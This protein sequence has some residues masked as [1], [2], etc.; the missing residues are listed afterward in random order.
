[1][2]LNFWFFQNQPF[3]FSKILSKTHNFHQHYYWIWLKP[4]TNSLQVL[5]H[6]REPLGLSSIK[7]EI[8][9]PFG[10]ILAQKLKKIKKK[11]LPKFFFPFFSFWN[12]NRPKWV[13]KFKFFRRQPK[14]LP[15]MRKNLSKNCYWLQPYS[16]IIV[17]KINNILQVKIW[18]VLFYL[19]TYNTILEFLCKWLFRE[20]GL[21]W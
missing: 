19:D 15:F 21:Y 14:R 4:V 5:S 3:I 10:S 1:M 13:K 2:G 17:T 16:I 20:F 12:Q 18:K 11:Q 6:K 8:F 7:F 9:D